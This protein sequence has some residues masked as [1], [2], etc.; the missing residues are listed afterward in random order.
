VR[1]GVSLALEP[2]GIATCGDQEQGCSI[3]AYAFHG[4]QLRRCFGHQRIQLLLQ[5]GDLFG[6]PSVAARHRAPGE[7]G[8]RLKVRGVLAR[9]KPRDLREQLRPCEPL[10]SSLLS[11]SGAVMSRFLSWLTAWAR[12][13][14]VER[15]V[16]RKVRIISTVPSAS[17]GLPV[18]VPASTA[19]V[20]SSASM[21]SDSPER[22][23]LRRLGRSSYKTL[24]PSA[25]KKRASPATKEP[26]P[27]IYVR[28]PLDLHVPSFSAQRASQIDVGSPPRPCATAL[29]TS[30]WGRC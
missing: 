21:G 14:T 22:Y 27:S 5:L 25:R 17:L 2:L 11:A 4:D 18:A 3:G 29:P 30:G 24:V 26:V 13:F 15:R 23:W 16:T 12:A 20:A 8:S 9:P 28:P 6:E 10:L 7:L 1:V 19:R